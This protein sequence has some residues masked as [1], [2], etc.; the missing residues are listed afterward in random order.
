MGLTVTAEG[1]ETEAQRAFLA[2]IGADDGQG[3]L[4]GRPVPAERLREQLA[5]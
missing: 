3:H 5:A 4:F 2:D 1:I